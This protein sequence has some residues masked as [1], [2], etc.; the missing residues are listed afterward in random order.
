MGSG[1]LGI[2]GFWR[3]IGVEEMGWQYIVSQ[4][5]AQNVFIYHL[6]FLSELDE[7]VD[8]QHFAMKFGRDELNPMFGGF[9]LG[10]RLLHTLKEFLALAYAC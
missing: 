1:E 3:R 5:A 8:Q 4:E 9:T 6:V 2:L 10:K 7:G